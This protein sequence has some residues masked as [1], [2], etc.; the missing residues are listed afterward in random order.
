MFRTMITGAMAVPVLALLAGSGLAKD[1]Y[2]PV[3]VLLQTETTV[4]GQPIVYPKGAAQ[5][6]VAIVTMQSGQQT[7]WHLHEA[8]LTAHILEGELTVDYG[9][10]GTRIYREGDTLVEAFGSRHA[11]HQYRRGACADLRGVRGGCRDARHGGRV[12]L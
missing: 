4:I 9:A 3:E 8:P 7:G 6:T 11:G 12:I 1:S 10:D 2:P 5:I